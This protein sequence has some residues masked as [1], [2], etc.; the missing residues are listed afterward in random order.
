MDG[1]ILLQGSR[2]LG[3]YLRSYQGLLGRRENWENFRIFVRGQLSPI[4]RKSLEPIA[5]LHG[6]PPRCLQRFFSRATWDEDGVRRKHQKR[7]ARRHGHEDGI[8]LVDET[9]DAK[10]GEW[11][12]GIQRQHCGETGKI[13]NC[14]V[15][16][17]LAYAHGDFQALLDGELFLPESWA[18]NPANPDVQEKR[19]RAQ[20]PPEVGHVTKPDL[21]LR[22]LRRAL[23]NGVPGRYVVADEAYGDLP[24]WRRAVGELGLTY[25]VET[26]GNRCFGWA[27]EPE[28]FTPPSKR[29]GGQRKPHP[30]I[31]ARKLGVLRD[32]PDGLRFR[33]R[34]RLR[35]KETHKGPELWEFKEAH[36]W[37]NRGKGRWRIKG[38][39][40]YPEVERVLVGENVRTGEVKF[41]LT[42]DLESSLEQLVAIAFSRW[43]IERCFQ[44]CKQELGL[45]HA[46]IRNYRGLQRHLI[47]TAVTYLFLQEFVKRHGLEKKEEA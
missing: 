2:E 29:Y 3:R 5:D 41:F 46:E 17:H 45:N 35:V 23:E 13:E 44:D 47:L 12:A 42:N 38:G 6:I 22:M 25:V 16:A 10:K 14:I 21:G 36:F 19:R 18:P 8:F 39:F 4:E 33:S 26:S 30:V 9:S 7:V 37:Q 40:H 32:A 15:S 43:R 24:K 31:P 28:S 34:V 27:N 1:E 20:I 11:T